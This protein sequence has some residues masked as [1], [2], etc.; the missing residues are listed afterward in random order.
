V[1]SSLDDAA[2]VADLPITKGN[3]PLWLWPNLLGLDAPV[4]AVVW[5]RF[6][7]VVH[8]VRA[9]VSASVTLGL[10]VWFVYLVDR[11]LDARPGRPVE[12]ADRHRF[13]RRNRLFVGVVATIAFTAACVSV[14]SLPVAY[15]WTGVVVAAGLAV[16]LVGVHA[17]T[18]S[19]FGESGKSFLVGMLFA[20]GVVVPLVAERSS[21]STEWLPAVGAFAAACWLNCR[22]IADWET[23]V[24]VRDR[25]LLLAAAVAVGLA[26]LAT[27]P[28][29]IAIGAGVCLLLTLHFSRRHLSARCRRV[30]ADVALLTPLVIG[31]VL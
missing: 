7:A 4:V 14:C 13:A 5:Q 20:A 8:G 6:L 11:W 10:V 1:T 27:W 16:Y 23:P 24:E 22:L 15:I 2:M 18:G 19:A 29:L 28:V 26:M 25:I 31:S 12:S 21:Q 9:P 3:Y 17:I 30:L